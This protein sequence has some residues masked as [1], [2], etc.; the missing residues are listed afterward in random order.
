MIKTPTLYPFAPLPLSMLFFAC[1]YFGSC[2]PTLRGDG[3]AAT[4]PA[5]VSGNVYEFETKD[6]KSDPRRK[7]NLDIYI[8]AGLFES[9]LALTQD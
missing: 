4:I 6:K 5:N 3:E 2:K 8:R 9:R 7:L 1:L